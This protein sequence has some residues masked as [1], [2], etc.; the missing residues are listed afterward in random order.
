MSGVLSVLAQ[1]GAE[2]GPQEFIT[3]RDKPLPYSIYG[4]PGVHFDYG[5][6]EQ[7]NNTIARGISKEYSWLSIDDDAGRE[8]L[9]MMQLM[10][11]YAQANHHL[12]HAHFLKRTGGPD[13]R[14]GG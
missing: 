4:T 9:Q 5:M 10:G 1:I 12:I 14:D 11:R 6:V 13:G 3:L 7:M 8:Y 2:F